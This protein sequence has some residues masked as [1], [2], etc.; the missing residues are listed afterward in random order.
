MSWVLVAFVMLA[1][2]LCEAAEVKNLKG[3][4]EDDLGVISYDLVGNLGERQGDVSV[5]LEISGKR[6]RSDQLNLKGDY[7][8]NIAVGLGKKFTWDI[9]KDFPAGFEGDTIWDVTAS[10]SLEERRFIAFD[11]GTVLDKRTNLMWAAKDNGVNINWSSA[12]SYC[13]NYRG[14][15]YAD[16]R[17]PTQNE[18]AELFN[19][20]KAQE[21][22]C[23]GSANHLATELIHLTCWWAWGSE[24]RGPDATVFNFD[25]GRRYWNRQS[26]GSI[27]RA[28]PVR[29]GPSVASSP[30]AVRDPTTIST[31]ETKPIDLSR[32]P[33]A[34]IEMVFIKGGCF[35]MGN[36]FDDVRIGGKPVHEVCVSDFKIG[37]YE[38]TQKQWMKAMGNNPSKH[39]IGFFGGSSCEDCPV[40]NVSWDEVNTFI[41]RLNS[42]TGE[43]FRLPTEAEWEY[44]AR[45]G[46]KNEKY[47]GAD[48]VD[49]VA[50]YSNNSASTTHPVGQ[51]QPNGFGIFD[52]SGNVWEWV[53]DWYDKDYYN[54]SP[55][56]NPDGPSTGSYRAIRGGGWSMEAWGVRAA[57]RGWPQPSPRHGALGFRLVLPA[58]R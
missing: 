46:G 48:N 29:S 6:Y 56:V 37:K 51:K 53:N 10:E 5:Y 42:Q 41:Q 7:G 21:V 38:V 50:W 39:H 43:K 20:E 35:L 24:T 9:L 13:E 18:L 52:M 4:M 26:Q 31:A 15:G 40:E 45:S 32:N 25:H 30:S 3:W 2:T 44:A 55:R 8:K 23:G 11:N 36:T 33:P 14:G 28:I 22:E 47:S 57:I 17:M 27:V 1:G 19:A 16:W 12:K 49:A 54:N 58:G 34:G